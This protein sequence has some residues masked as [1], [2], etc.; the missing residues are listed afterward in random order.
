MMFSDKNLDIGTNTLKIGDETIE[1]IG[2]NCEEKFFFFLGHVL[3][4]KLGGPYL[5]CCKKNQLVQIL[6]VIN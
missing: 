2:S 4:D 6:V 5:T 3:N 1:Q